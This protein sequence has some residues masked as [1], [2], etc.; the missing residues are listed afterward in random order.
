MVW[1]ANLPAPFRDRPGLAGTHRSKK[2]WLADVGS[3]KQ[4]HLRT[5]QD[6]EAGVVGCW[7]KYF[8]PA[9]SGIL[10]LSVAGAMGVLLASAFRGLEGT[11][12]SSWVLCAANPWAS[13]GWGI[14][15]GF[16]LHPFW[17]ISGHVG[18]FRVVTLLALALMGY[19]FSKLLILA[20]FR[21]GAEGRM[22]RYAWIL[23]PSLLCAVLSRYS[24]GTRTPS[25]DWGLLFG[26]LLFVS[27]WLW[28]GSAK[29]ELRIVAPSAL[30]SLGVVVCLINKWVVFPGYLLLVGVL[31]GVCFPPRDRKRIGLGLGIWG[32]VWFCL[33][34]FY[35]TPGGFMDTVRAGMAQLK[36]GSHANLLTH[37]GVGVLK[38]CWQ[39]IRAYPWAV[40]LFGLVWG[41]LYFFGGKKKPDRTNVAGLT[42]LAALILLLGR[43]HWQGGL[44]TFSKG[45]MM[46]VVWL[47]GV[48]LMARP[49]WKSR[50]DSR[51][52]D[53][54]FWG[55][56]AM[57]CVVPWLN[58]VGTAT[59]ITDYLVHGT[60]FFVATG[61]VF[62]GRALAGGL[63][64]WCMAAAALMLGV[65]HSARAIT[66]TWNTYR[67][68]SVWTE[69]VPLTHGPEKGRLL[70]F[71]ASGRDLGELSRDME[72][73]GFQVGD[74]IL[75]I[76]DLCDL[77]YLL[78]GVSPGVA[79]YMG[80]WL[81][82]NDGVKSHLGN[83]PAD[84]LKR[85]WVLLKKNAK[86]W[87]KI[88]HVWP[89]ESGIPLPHR[90]EKKYFWPW[91][92]GAG[93]PEEIYLYRPASPNK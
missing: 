84:V 15:F 25:Y 40:G 52:E 33:F 18:A 27:G 5:H 46:V 41:L 8:P 82:E 9:V 81:P 77:V 92:D 76:T 53:K 31:V 75:G 26:A 39:V 12:E 4:M 20:E 56:T 85:S 2:G 38:G 91:G 43:G 13:P 36:V 78:G 54:Y 50:R 58:G 1:A 59:G 48:F 60:V 16:F 65:I 47:T 29:A 7:G 64:P 19:G 88:E 70:S 34:L 30:C 74:P 21:L 79:W 37:Y 73:M 11:D 68:G 32:L 49:F 55:T 66:S 3:C 89:A 69:M 6:K 93:V 61:W 83:V 51:W 90:V 87:E 63:P 14:H 23:I 22:S 35:A 24:I 28:M 17:Q 67:I 80:H 45:M 44:T 10:W 71:G 57:L 72:Q 86:K 62:L 42:F